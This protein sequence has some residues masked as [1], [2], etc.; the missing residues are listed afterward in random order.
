MPSEPSAAKTAT[1]KPRIG[2]LAPWFGAKRVLAPEIV[3][4]L[5]SHTAYWEPLCGSMAVLMAKP[6]VSMETVNDMHGELINLA[7]VVRD[8]VDGPKLYRRLRRLIVSD[9]VRNSVKHEQP[10]NRVDRAASYFIE[11]WIG[12]NGVSGTSSTNGGF[13]QRFTSGGGSPSTRFHSAVSSIPAWRRR[14]R[15]VVILNIDGFEM[16]DR[17]E[18]SDRCAIYCDPPYVKKGARYVHDFEEDDHRRLATLLRR[19]TKTRVVLSYYDHPLVRDLY[20][21]WTIRKMSVTKSLVNQGR[22]DR[23]GAVK[24]PELLLINGASLSESDGL[25]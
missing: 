13:C 11:S 4:E 16:L 3:R 14:L 2:A 10:L 9:F 24:A 7:E 20:A 6:A 25:F 5:G 12:R 15:R 22:R 1:D 17:L 8:T 18:D 23:G 19:F 21:G